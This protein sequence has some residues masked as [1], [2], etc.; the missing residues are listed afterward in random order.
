MTLKISISSFRSRFILGA[1]IWASVALIVCGGALSMLLRE[2]LAFL[3]KG[4]LLEHAVELGELARVDAHGVSIRQPLSDPRFSGE[5]SGYYWQ[6]RSPDGAITGSPSL[7]SARLAFG[8]APLAEGGVRYVTI[9]GPTGDLLFLEHEVR[10]GGVGRRLRIGVGMDK[11]LLDTMS[12]R[13]DRAIFGTLAS[14]GAGLLLGTLAQLHISLRFLGRI[15]D[16]LKQIREGD[17]NRLP[18]DM[19]DEVLPLVKEFNGLIGVNEEIVRRARL[20]AGNLAHA[21]KTPLAILLHEA[22][23]MRAAGRE[24]E[25]QRVLR[26]CER[27]Q[28]VLNYQLVR[29]RASVTQSGVGAVARVRPLIHSDVA[30]LSQLYAARGLTFDVG[31]IDAQAK[32]ACASEDFEEMFASLVDNAAKWATRRVR[33]CAEAEGKIFRVRVEDDGCGLPKEARERVFAAGERLDE[34]TPGSGLGLAIV[35]DIATLYG[36][37]AWIDASPLGGASACLELP[38]AAS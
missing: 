7:G 2:E 8:K 20:E 24:Q 19:P 16:A 18:E 6:L 25:S 36:G 13:F 14:V 29:T 3:Y 38:L 33:I 11:S 27:M 37:R 5:R 22:E 32:I 21:L 35:R 1:V 30:A 31:D 9:A 26:Q 28:R 17:A 23:A 4:E 12:S 34:A 10:S 15:R